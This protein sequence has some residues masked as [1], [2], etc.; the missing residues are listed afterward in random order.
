[1]DN[2]QVKNISKLMSLVLRHEPE[3]LGIILDENGWANVAQLIEKMNAKGIR[4]DFATIQTVV[5]TNDKKR[6]AFNDDKTM[7]R[8]SQGHSIEVD[9]QLQPV[10]PPAIL[11]HGTASRFVAG[12]LRDG[13]QK[14]A[15]QHVHLSKE[16][17]TAHNVGTRHGKAVILK[18][19]AAAMHT[20]GYHFY[21]S[22]NGVWLTDHVPA[23]FLEIDE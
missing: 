12:I 17:G 6:F 8:A 16:T 14:R 10:V 22:A 19:D 4:A 1:M 21:C 3:H 5:D 15:R 9:L 23:G 13:L 7:I 11:Y 18:V 2:K 20:A